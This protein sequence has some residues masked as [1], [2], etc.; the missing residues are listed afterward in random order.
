MANCGWCGKATHEFD[1]RSIVVPGGGMRR[2][3]TGACWA[4]LWNLFHPGEPVNVRSEV[5]RV[6]GR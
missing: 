3:H 2:V 1:W 4:K 6:N 5:A